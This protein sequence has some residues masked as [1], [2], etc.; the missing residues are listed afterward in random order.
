MRQTDRQMRT[1][2]NETELPRVE[3]VQ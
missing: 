2:R 1:V 3:R